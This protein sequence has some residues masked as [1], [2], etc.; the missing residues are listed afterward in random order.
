[1]DYDA[2]WEVLLFEA[3]AAHLEK[4]AGVEVMALCEMRFSGLMSEGESER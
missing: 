3:S 2:P 1:M 4:D